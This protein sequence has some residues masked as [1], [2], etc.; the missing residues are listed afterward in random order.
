MSKRT[1]S[2][3]DT[4]E[5]TLHGGPKHGS[6]FSIPA[7]RRNQFLIAMPAPVTVAKREADGSDVVLPGLRT[8]SYTRVLAIGGTP[9]S[10]FEW[11]GWNRKD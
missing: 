11:I 7:D 6:K 8:G 4:E 2:D 5:I 3:R 9:T 1:A 10:D